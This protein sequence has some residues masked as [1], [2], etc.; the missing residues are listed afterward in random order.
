M[1][2]VKM[3]GGLGNQLFQYA[4]GMYI[5]NILEKEV[6][7]DI[8]LN[9]FNNNLTP[10]ELEITKL[11]N[12]PIAQSSDLIG[13]KIFD[14]GLFWRIER[15]LNQVFPFINS[16]YY[17]QKNPHQNEFIIKDNA[18]YEG[19]WQNY[20]YVKSLIEYTLSN[21]SG[22]KHLII[23]NKYYN[24]IINCNSISIHIRRDD[25]LKNTKIFNILDLEYYNRAI[26]FIKDK[27]QSPKFFIFTQDIKWAEENFPG[28]EFIIVSNNSAIED[29][30]LMSIC[31][32][33]VIANSTFSW[34]SAW[35]NNSPEKIIISP[36]HWYNNNLNNSI[37][38]L[39]P[40]TWIS[41]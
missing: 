20:F 21:I 5:N 8:K 16:N 41:F 17:V 37:I 1:I 9:N 2:I 23:N 34:W 12:V 10:R 24:E 19:Y 13:K 25:Y 40:P 11:F 38:N 18:Y 14:S 33:N 30:L 3:F 6:S 36:K 35:L 7:F 29:L 4:F 15:K 26:R 27:T 31:K 39:I 32:H 22:C 28:E